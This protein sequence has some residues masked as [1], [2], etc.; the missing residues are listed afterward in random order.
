MSDP[1]YVYVPNWEEH[2]PRSDR[3]NLPWLRLHTKLLG[4][5]AWLNLSCEDRCLLIAIWM[6]IQR[7]GNGCLMADQRWLM[8][9]ANVPFGARSKNLERLVQ[10][11]FIELSTT[12]AEPNGG[13]EERRETT[14]LRKEEKKNAR[15]AHAENGGARAQKELPSH[16]RPFNPVNNP[17]GYTKS[18]GPPGLKEHEEFK[19]AG[20]PNVHRMP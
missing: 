16:M 6:L 7:Y 14:S 20:L 3:P 13:L 1:L 11:G 4:S 2:Q 9:Q 18:E 19:A 12:K 5:P 15:A 8:N 17:G 10:A